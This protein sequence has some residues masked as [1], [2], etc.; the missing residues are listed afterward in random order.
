MAKQVPTLKDVAQRAGVAVQTV[1][2]IIHDRPGY[3]SETRARVQAAIDDL[4]YRPFSVAQSL[5]THQTQTIALVISDIA[6]PSFATIASAAE[7]YA[8]RFGYSLVVYNTHDD[9]A[10][11]TSCIHSVTQRWI[12]GV[13]FVSADDTVAG[14][15]ALQKAQIPVVAIDRIP[16]DYVGPSVVLDNYQAGCMAAEH[17]LALGHTSLGHISSG[18]GLRLARERQAGFVQT[19]LQHGLSPAICSADGGSWRCEWG[20]RAMQQLL[21]A[22]P[23][24]TAVFAANDRIAIGAMRALFE[25]G[26]RVPQDISVIGLDD[27]EV[28][29]YQIPPLTTIRQSF[30]EIATHAVQLLLDLLNGKNPARL[31]IVIEPS[32][33][34]RSSAA[35]PPARRQLP[36]APPATRPEKGGD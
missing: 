7:D 20:Y 27:I 14:L 18:A 25:A 31:Q 26:V 19:L 33:V 23:A 2:S 16:R 24:L 15:N 8:H 17:L 5:R 9:L 6:N 34:V 22:A 4:G 28:A 10:R 32:L 36:I 3:T 35:A 21:Q 13:I 29:A 11:E 30:A 12:D 1:S